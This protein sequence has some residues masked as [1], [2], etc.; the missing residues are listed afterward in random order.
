MFSN[1][2]EEVTALTS[3]QKIEALKRVIESVQSFALW[4]TVALAV[5]LVV[6]GLVVKFRFPE[7]MRAFALIAVGTVLGYAL[8]L[9]S[10][11]LYMQI[12]RMAWKNEIDTNFWLLV[13]L[14]GYALVAVIANLFVALFAKKALKAVFWTSLALFA[15]Y[16]VAIL[17]VFPTYEGYEPQNNALYIVLTVALVAVIAVLSLLFD[18]KKG[19]AAQTKQLAYAGIC[20]ATAFALSYVKFF[21]LPMGGSVTLVSMLPIMLYAYMFGAKKGVIAGVIYGILQ[22]IQSPQIYEPVQVLLDYPIA[23]GALGLAGIFKGMKG[24]KGNMLL[25]FLLGMVVACLGR[26]FAHVLSGYFVFYSWSTFEQGKELL[27]S[28][29]YNAFIFVD[30]ALDVIV[31]AALLSSKTMQRQIAS[32]NPTGQPAE[33]TD[34][35]TDGENA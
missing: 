25:E 35:T 27:Y 5:V 32:V 15:G 24:L 33:K 21:S 14:F 6:A 7:K 22:C 10:V 11:I 13:G 20:I 3:D 19:T 2:D 8:T 34:K 18:R 1:W 17:C 29:A 28:L 4:V 31:G 12:T 16:L 30:L 23:F 9:I 26:Y